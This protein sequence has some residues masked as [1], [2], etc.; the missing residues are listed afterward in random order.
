MKFFKLALISFVILAIVVIVL[1]L[2]LPSRVRVSRAIDI[3]AEK[4]MVD[5]QVN[6]LRN[7]P[8]WNLFVT[9]SN[10]DSIFISRLL[11]QT[12][13]LKIKLV[14]DDEQVVTSWQQGRSRPFDGVLVSTPHENVIT[15]QW[16]FDFK[17][18]WYPW[19]KFQSI[20]YD[21]QLG[22]T[23]EKS[24]ENLRNLAEN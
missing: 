10:E 22:P 6:D 13:K 11:L 20:I 2:L 21:K 16:Y 5:A 23:M 14:S 15:V 19:Q 12:S 8:H 9:S 18:D 4:Q 17:L 1:S 7:W 3:R 24:L